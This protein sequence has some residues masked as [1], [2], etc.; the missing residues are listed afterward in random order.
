MVLIGLS[1]CFFLFWLEIKRWQ[2]INDSIKEAEKLRNQFSQGNQEPS[3]GQKKTWRLLNQVCL[4]QKR[5]MGL[6][7]LFSKDSKLLKEE[8][9]EFGHFSMISFASLENVRGILL[10]LIANQTKLRFKEEGPKL[11]DSESKKPKKKKNKK[12]RKINKPQATIESEIVSLSEIILEFEDDKINPSKQQKFLEKIPSEMMK[13]TGET[14]DK[15]RVS[16]DLA[17]PKEKNQENIHKASQVSIEKTQDV[18]TSNQKEIFSGKMIKRRTEVAKSSG[19]S[20]SEGEDILKMKNQEK[21]ACSRSSSAQ[22]RITERKQE[23]KPP[24]RKALPDHGQPMGRRERGSED[25]IKEA[26]KLQEEPQKAPFGSSQTGHQGSKKKKALSHTSEGGKEP[27]ETQK[28]KNKNKVVTPQCEM[29]S[30]SG[31]SQIS[32]QSFAKKAISEKENS[33]SFKFD[34]TLSQHYNEYELIQP[35]PRQPNQWTP[36][37]STHSEDNDPNAFHSG[38]QLNGLAMKSIYSSWTLAADSDFIEVSK[39]AR[40]RQPKH[41]RLHENY[42]MSSYQ[43]SDQKSCEN[44]KIRSHNISNNYELQVSPINLRKSTMTQ[45]SSNQQSKRNI[46]KPEQLPYKKQTTMEPLKQKASQQEKA[47]RPLSGSTN[48]KSIKAYK[49]WQDDMPELAPEIN[50]SPQPLG[51]QPKK[52]PELNR[53]EGILRKRDKSLQYQAPNTLSDFLT[54]SKTPPPMKPIKQMANEPPKPPH[55]DCFNDSNSAL[56]QMSFPTGRCHSP[57]YQRDFGTQ[58]HMDQFFS[59]GEV[60]FLVDKSSPFSLSNNNELANPYSREGKFQHKS[61]P[62]TPKNSRDKIK[63][64]EPNSPTTGSRGASKQKRPAENEPKH[65]KRPIPKRWSYQHPEEFGI[66]EVSANSHKAHQLSIGIMLEKLQIDLEKSYSQLRNEANRTAPIRSRVLELLK[67]TVKSVF[68]ESFASGVDAELFGSCRTSLAL[69][70]SDIDVLLRGFNCSS[71]TDCVEVLQ[72][73]KS[74]LECFPWAVKI[75]PVFTASV[76]LLKVRCDPNMPMMDEIG[77]KTDKRHEFL[78]KLASKLPIQLV[79]GLN[80]EKV[81]VGLLKVDITVQDCSNGQGATDHIGQRSTLFTSHLLETF[82][83]LAFLTILIKKILYIHK[84][85]KPFKGTLPISFQNSFAFSS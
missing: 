71:K 8:C 59:H 50:A 63:L 34:E 17:K 62:S 57:V 76:P 14:P 85:H 10:M 56:K 36:A 41:F 6:S 75:K 83:H 69:P 80:P 42:V 9:K 55:N 74:H 39:K 82:P 72:A 81:K 23:K 44:M 47:H 77:K 51:M 46:M 60:N 37:L 2:I 35:N 24:V 4:L 30:S 52:E 61:T 3:Q 68:E 25:I 70:T 84:L 58:P 15:K 49:K 64:K 65:D 29:V 18:E 78:S 1:L 45:G 31:K 22:Q 19:S 13:K 43:S 32:H 66:K 20:L 7:Q 5:N 53:T 67:L 54:S 33:I 12:K 40:R 48:Q 11:A 38:S 16:A 26:N 73:L 28:P 21:R 27:R 79:G